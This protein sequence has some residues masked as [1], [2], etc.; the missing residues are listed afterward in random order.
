MTCGRTLAIHDLQRIYVLVTYSL[1]QCSV[2]LRRTKLTLIIYSAPLYIIVVTGNELQRIYKC[3][4][5]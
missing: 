1:W 4:I 3:G 2:Q 5:D